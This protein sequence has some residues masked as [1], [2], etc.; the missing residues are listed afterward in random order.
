MPKLIKNGQFVD[1]PWTIIDQEGD[2]QSCLSNKAEYLIVPFSLWSED[3]DALL[4]SGKTIAVWLDSDEEP[5]ALADDLAQLPMVALHF[6]SFRDGRAF[7]SAVILR[8]RYHYEG[9]IRAIGEVLRDQL[10]YMK[11]CGFD[12][13]DVSDQVK[14][15]DA[16]KAFADF[17]TTYASTIEEP[18]PLFRRR[19]DAVAS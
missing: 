19:D 16:L 3:K 1:N 4:D 18:K 6:P 14:E 17:T 15:E 9:E 10:F 12:A 8:Q 11:R 13:F 7:S 2:L 5:E